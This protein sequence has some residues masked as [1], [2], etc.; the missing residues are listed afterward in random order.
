MKTFKGERK[1]LLNGK[2]VNQIQY[3]CESD[4]SGRNQYIYQ[5]SSK[6]ERERLS[7]K[8]LT[9][10]IRNGKPFNKSGFDIALEVRM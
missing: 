9:K 1:V 3:Y 7:F 6:S 10:R 8:K 5:N 2:I 4:L